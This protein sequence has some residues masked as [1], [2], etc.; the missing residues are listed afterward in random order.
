MTEAAAVETITL[1]EICEELG[2]KPASARQKLRAKMKDSKA[3]NFRWVFP[4]EQKDEIVELLKSKAKPGAEE[5]D[6]D[7][8]ADE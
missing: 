5:G 1:K 3:D 2:I 6:D 7:E 4:V 8:G